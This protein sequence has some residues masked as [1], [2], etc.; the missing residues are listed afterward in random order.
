MQASAGN[1]TGTS[2]VAAADAPENCISS[3]LLRDPLGQPIVQVDG[4]GLA[5]IMRYSG[6][7]GM[8]GFQDPHN[9]PSYS[10]VA[11][12]GNFTIRFYLPLELDSSGYCSIPSLNAA[13]Q[14]TL[15][16]TLASA[17]TVYGTQ[18]APIVPTCTVT[19]DQQYWAAP[20]GQ[21]D[22][23]PPDVGSSAQSSRASITLGRSWTVCQL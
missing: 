4:Y 11:S 17:A 13:A 3:L 5:S 1:G 9:L 21:P 18:P 10:A 20:V 2:A 8:A 12:T 22:L 14:P 23:G 16:I 19:V 7:F 6:Q 15:Q